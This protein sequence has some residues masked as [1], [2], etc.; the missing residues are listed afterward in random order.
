VY[1]SP[2]NRA[3]KTALERGMRIMRLCAALRS[4]S[5][6]EIGRCAEEVS[7]SQI[8]IMGNVHACTSTQNGGSLSIMSQKYPCGNLR[9]RETE[10]SLLESRMLRKT[11]MSSSEEGGWKSRQCC[12]LAAYPTT[13]E[14]GESCLLE[15]VPR[16][17]PLV[18][19][20]QSGFTRI[21][22]D[23]PTLFQVST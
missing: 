10:L 17:L 14:I 5:R 2:T 1:V 13:P 7:W 6:A 11:V 3:C 15:V 18:G 9:R 4:P 19:I 21:I 12:S 23:S 8:A 16:K 20:R 22:R